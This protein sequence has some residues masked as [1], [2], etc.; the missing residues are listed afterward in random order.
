[1]AGWS[2]TVLKCQARRVPSRIQSIRVTK[3][4]QARVWTSW[5]YASDKGV[6]A[7][8]SRGC[9]SGGIRCKGSMT[10]DLCHRCQRWNN[11]TVDNVSVIRLRGSWFADKYPSNDVTLVGLLPLRARSKACPKKVV[12]VLQEGRVYVLDTEHKVHCERIKLH[13]SRPTEFVAAPVN[14]SDIVVRMDP[15][16]NIPPTSL[17]MAILSVPTEHVLSEVSDLSLPHQVA[18]LIGSCA[19][20]AIV[21]QL[22][23]KLAWCALRRLGDDSLAGEQAHDPHM[24]H[25]T[26][27]T[28]WRTGMAHVSI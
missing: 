1:M 25:V 4:V 7:S 14:G 20:I 3:S 13:Q 2:I 15:Y 10:W 26:G 27:K 23:A 19:D 22:L 16:R 8:S 9:A 5:G 11:Q 21:F 28:G 24:P 6:G 12:H 18:D 17:T